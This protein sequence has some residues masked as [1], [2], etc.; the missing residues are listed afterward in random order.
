VTELYVYSDDPA[1]MANVKNYSEFWPHYTFLVKE[2]FR[3]LTP[4]RIVA[5][6][7][8]DLPTYKRNGDE[9]GIRDFP[10]DLIRCHEAAG[11]IY[12][13]PR[14]CIWKN[15]L[16]AATRTKAIGLAHKQIVKDSS[17]CRSGIPDC[18]LAFRKPG[19]NP[20]PIRHEKG[21]TT[22][23][24]SREVPHTFD[25][26]VNLDLSEEGGQGKNKRSQWIWQQIASPVWFDIRQTRCLHFK[27]ARENED[28]KHICPFALD[29]VERCLE[30]WSTAG[31]VVL[32]PF[33]GVGSV[34]YVAVKN[35]RKGLGVELKASYFNMAKRN[36]RMLNKDTRKAMV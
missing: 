3:I 5:V 35:G 8:M 2:L 21:L 7:A 16:V 14:I 36:L 27:E 23:Y 11:F 24:G 4:G 17:L 19:E 15:P 28:E 34:P 22:Y 1:D 13:C 25:R 12:H 6:H 20:K 26:F 18:I 10:G 9:I 30:L 33:M 31:D 32:D 29:T